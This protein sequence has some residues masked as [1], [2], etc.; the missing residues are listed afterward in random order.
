MSAGADAV[1]KLLRYI[2]GVAGAGAAFGASKLVGWMSWTSLSGELS[3]FLATYLVVTILVDRALAAY[4]TR[5]G[6]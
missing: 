5:P 1:S 2:P 4:G 3:V 6:A